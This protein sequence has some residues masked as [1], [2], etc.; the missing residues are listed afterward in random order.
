MRQRIPGPVKP[1]TCQG[2]PS[3]PMTGN[4]LAAK[5]CWIVRPSSWPAGHLTA[6]KIHHPFLSAPAGPA[7]PIT[8][9]PSNG[10]PGHHQ[11]SGISQVDQTEWECLNSDWLIASLSASVY[12]GMSSSS[13]SVLT[14]MASLT[15]CSTPAGN[16]VK[17]VLD[18]ILRS[19][20]TISVV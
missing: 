19:W 9:S 1:L 10:L 5:G 2:P 16:T 17:F 15:I 18:S 4:S 13:I 7:W 6:T 3:P 14:A 11:T 8:H 20:A 12:Q